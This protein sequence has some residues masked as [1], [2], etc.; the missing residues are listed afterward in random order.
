MALAYRLTR[1][2]E[3]AYEISRLISTWSFEAPLS[4]QQRWINKETREFEVFVAAIRP[5]PPM[6]SLLFSEGIHHVRSALDNAVWYLV[7]L[8]HGQVTDRQSRQVAMPIYEDR[9]KYADWVAGRERAGLACYA[10]GSVLGGRI[11]S[12]QPFVDDVERV[13]SMGEVLSALT[14]TGRE[15]V[16]PLRLLQAYSNGDKH[17]AVRV[18]ASR[19][20]KTTSGTPIWEQE[21]HQRDFQVGDV[22]GTGKMGEPSILETNVAATIPR[23]APWEAWVNPAKE[24]GHLRRFVAD[25]AI[26]T[27]VTGVALPAG[28][29]PAS[30]DLTDTGQTDGERVAAATREDAEQRFHLELSEL[31]SRAI[32][33]APDFLQPSDG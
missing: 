1:A 25:I 3:C 31:F 20:F 21:R 19:G 26:P 33:R 32:S 6:V 29:I 28:G 23:P 2:D 22:L 8:E 27:L 17:R 30:I 5:I 12:L 16:H 13:E 9:Q 4:L 11:R 15:T 14:G 7:A 24:L 10:D 18:A